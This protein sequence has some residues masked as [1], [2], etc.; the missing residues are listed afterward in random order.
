MRNIIL[1]VFLSLLL[2]LI[3]LF[4]CN[5]SVY[6]VELKGKADIGERCLREHRE[7]EKIMMKNG[8]E[9]EVV[10]RYE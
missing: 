9:W 8:K 7:K 1:T 10:K 4:L 2:I 5:M 3:L 6:M